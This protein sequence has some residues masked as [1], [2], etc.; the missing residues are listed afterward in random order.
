MCN[1]LS[2][3]ITNER[4]PR[5]L[6][7][8]LLHH[9]KTIEAFGL[10]PETYREWEWTHDDDGASLVVRAAPQENANVLKSAILAKY[11]HRAA[12]L[13]ECI[14]QLQLQKTVDASGCTGLTKLDAPNAEYVDARG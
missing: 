7:A 12:C 9:E 4:E 11:P 8:N 2:G 3:V 10:K 13:G 14:R 1:F 5:V 6:C